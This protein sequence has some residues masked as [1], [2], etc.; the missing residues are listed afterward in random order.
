MTAGLMGTRWEEQWEGE[1]GMQW[2]QWMDAVTWV[3]RP[4]MHASRPRSQQA[5]A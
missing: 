2:M 3:S 5:G 4:T 1:E